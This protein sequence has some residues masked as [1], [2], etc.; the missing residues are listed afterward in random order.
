[1]ARIVMAKQVRVGA[2]VTIVDGQVFF[3]GGHLIKE[4]PTLYD[5]NGNYVT[6]VNIHFLDLA[7]SHKDLSSDR[8]ALCRYWSFLE[9]EQLAWDDFSM[10]KNFKPTYR[11]RN[12]LKRAADNGEIAYSTANSYVCR[13]VKFYKFAMT[14]G[15][16]RI[17]DEKDAPFK[18]EWIDIVR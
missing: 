18:F 14:N 4:I 5:C 6:P 9:R 2:K 17:S 16:L 12:E 1:M 13:M 11:W 15:L 7:V 8:R 10:P 3:S